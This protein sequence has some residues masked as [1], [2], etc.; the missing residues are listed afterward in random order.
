M[1]MG[2][3]PQLSRIDERMDRIDARLDRLEDGFSAETKDNAEFRGEVRQFM[4]SLKEYIQAVSVK[5]GV[6]SS[7]LQSHKDD[8][9]AHGAGVKRE[10]N[11]KFVAWATVISGLLGGAVEALVHK[12]ITG[13]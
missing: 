5:V 10:I 6:V 11:G 4:P 7:S 8:P 9:D 2:D 3:D 12:G 1:P 13:K